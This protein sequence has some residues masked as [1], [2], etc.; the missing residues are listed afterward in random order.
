MEK[1]I[2]IGAGNAG[3]P[4]A[5]LLNHIGV[6]VTL[7]DKKKYEEF[8]PR[9]QKLL[10]VLVDEGINLDLG[11]DEPDIDGYDAIYLAPTIPESAPIR[12]EAQKQAKTIITRKMISQIIDDILDM[13]KI[14]ITGSFGKTTTTTMVTKIFEAAGYN[15]YQCSSMKQNLVSEA[16]VN[17]II[18]GE[19]KGAD[20]AIL[21]LPHGTLGLIGEIKL[22]MGLITNLIP[23][24]LSEFGGSMQ[25]YVDRKSIIME[26]SDTLIANCQCGDILTNKRED[27]IYYNMIN[28]FSED[29]DLDN[30]APS[31]TGRVEQN[32]YII[33]YNDTETEI[34]L[35]TVANYNYENLTAA[36]AC[37][38]TYGLSIDDVK[39]GIES[40]ESVGGRMEYLGKFNGIDAYYDASY[41]QSIRQA[42]ESIKDENIIIVFGSVDSTTTRDKAESG[43]IVGDYAD[44]VIATGYVEITDS[45]D[46]N[47]AF[48][49]LDAID[50][51]EVIKMAVC[52]VDEAA[53]LAIKHAKEGDIIVHLGAGASNSYQQVKDKYLKGLTEGSK[54]YA[55]K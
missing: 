33:S 6:F 29:V 31:F 13:D 8:T 2:V 26:T 45:L 9:R 53:Q 20:I 1:C 51:D 3:R 34:N 40:F 54:L 32:K 24:H 41:G 39:R 10:D 37:S 48:E 42:L 46:M 52:D 17:D 22:K 43:K 30:Y 7:Y 50:N 21:E 25:R 14:G 15:V 55:D 5:K 19:Y 49:L 23:E 11:L 28:S 47:R 44:M 16:L 36:I 38:L 4:V 27:T 12:M 35:K 18:N